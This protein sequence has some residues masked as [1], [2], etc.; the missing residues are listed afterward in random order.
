MD[1]SYAELCSHFE[2]C[3]AACEAMNFGKVISVLNFRDH[4][5]S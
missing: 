3:V 2:A 1:D 5:N 4:A